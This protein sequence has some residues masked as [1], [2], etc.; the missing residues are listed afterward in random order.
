[1]RREATPGGN[2]AIAGLLPGKQSN[3]PLPLAGPEGL[4]RVYVNGAGVLEEL[5]SGMSLYRVKP[6]LD[7][8]RYARAL[9]HSERDELKF[10]WADSQSRWL[11]VELHAERESPTGARVILQLQTIDPPFGLTLRELDVLTL[12]AAGFGNEAIALRLEVSARTVTKHVENIFT[13][14]KTAR[15]AG[16]AGMATD[17]G[18]LRLPTP[19]GPESFPLGTGTIERLARQLEHSVPRPS[20]RIGKRPIYVGMP[21]ALTGQ[22]KP[23]A[24]EMLSGAQLA[25]AEINARGG[26]LGR[27]I[28][29]LTVDCDTGSEASVFQA[30]SQLICAEVD[31][32]T[33]GY[34]C[35]ETKIQKLIADYRGP[36]LHAATMASAVQRVRDDLSN[37][38]NIFQVCAS[39]INYGLGLARCLTELESAGQ[40]RPRNRRLVVLQPV[41]PGLDIGLAELDRRTARLGWEIRVLSD[42]PQENVD[43]DAVIRTLHRL[44]PSV[45]VLASYF[46]EHS[47][48]FQRAFLKQPIAALVY[49]LYS[50][51]VPMYLDALGE[52]AN[53]VLWATTTGLYSDRI[54]KAFVA[55]YQQQFGR[56]PGQSHA[57]IAYDRINI[58]AGAWSRIGNSRRFDKVVADLRSSVYR[59]VNGAYYFGTD[60]QVGLAFPD[61]TQDPSISQAHLVFQIQNGLHRILSPRPYANGVF[62]LPPWLERPQT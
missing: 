36:Y 4:A 6:H 38:G 13:K 48:P 60:G 49:N 11:F 14:T 56:N 29:L 41:W 1:M 62:K 50:P 23:D 59:G 24:I 15:R 58:L 32:I 7:L 39:D 37:L 42:L 2:A 47:I 17:R 30:Y 10:I 35:V 33:A 16:V 57:S 21:L 12:I 9:I 26:V 31:A 53:G 19:G 43:W 44:D 61:D 55:R 27:E 52:Q 25:V 20:S 8:I 18:L 5:D 34:S 28:Q 3:Q 54:G 40:W 51:S 45:V 22:G 46:T